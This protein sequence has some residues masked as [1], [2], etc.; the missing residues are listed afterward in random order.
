MSSIT[1]AEAVH[2]ASH[3]GYVGGAALIEPVLVK[4]FHSSSK[5]ILITISISTFLSA[6]ISAV[7]ASNSARKDI[8]A[9]TVTFAAVLVV[10][11]GTRPPNADVL[12]LG[13][14]KRMTILLQANSHAGG[15]KRTSVCA[16]LPSRPARLYGFI[17]MTENHV[18]VQYC[19][20]SYIEG[21]VKLT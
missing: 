6:H 3:Y 10:S 12:E 17:N 21:A 19:L 5:I 11:I 7:I 20:W 8:L 4:K 15:D 13:N 1:G 16:R 18:P 9:A 14:R 2:F